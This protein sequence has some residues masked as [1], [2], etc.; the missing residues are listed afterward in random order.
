MLSPDRL[1]QLEPLADA[2]ADYDIVRRAIAFVSERWR[3]Q[4]EIEVIAEAVTLAG[5]F[6]TDEIPAVTTD[7]RR[8][9]CPLVSEYLMDETQR[10]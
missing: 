2:A 3:A 7:P 9:I 4:P 10:P 6:S 1:A 8:T 5:S